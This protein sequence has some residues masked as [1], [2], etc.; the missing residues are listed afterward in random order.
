MTLLLFC[1]LRAHQITLT[2]FVNSVLNRQIQAEVTQ[3]ALLLHSLLL[4]LYLNNYCCFISPLYLTYHLSTNP[5]YLSYALH[6]LEISH[7]TGDC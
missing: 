3:P 7:H 1:L 2:Y 4:Q 5:V 6:N